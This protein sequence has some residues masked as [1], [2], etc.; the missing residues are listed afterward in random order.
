MNLA[1]IRQDLEVD[2]NDFANI[3]YSKTPG[4]VWLSMYNEIAE[5][6]QNMT[7]EDIFDKYNKLSIHDSEFENVYEFLLYKSILADYLTDLID[8]DDYIINKNLQIK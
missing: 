8:E 1:E 2:L 6:H 5:E 7:I 4:L 3:M